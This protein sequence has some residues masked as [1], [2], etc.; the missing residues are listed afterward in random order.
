MS[1]EN[2]LRHIA[3]MIVTAIIL[4]LLPMIAHF[5]GIINPFKDLPLLDTIFWIS[6][7]GTAGVISHMVGGNKD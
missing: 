2:F 6:G 1:S 5:F 7:I 4:C 3:G